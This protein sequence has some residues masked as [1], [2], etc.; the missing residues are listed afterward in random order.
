MLQFKR[1]DEVEMSNCHSLEEEI[2]MLGSENRFKVLMIRLLLHLCKREH[3]DI[4][5]VW[6]EIHK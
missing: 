3:K 2:K 1:A 4:V 6:A 5:K